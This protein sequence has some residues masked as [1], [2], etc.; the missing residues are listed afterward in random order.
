MNKLVQKNVLRP[1]SLF[2]PLGAICLVKPVWLRLSLQFS[3]LHII[4]DGG[5]RNFRGGTEIDS[6]RNQSIRST[7]KETGWSSQKSEDNRAPCS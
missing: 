2:P 5:G 6:L 1:R 3:L 7:W 4:D